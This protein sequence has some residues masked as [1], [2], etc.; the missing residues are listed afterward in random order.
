[1]SLKMLGVG[2][3]GRLAVPQGTGD[4]KSWD[5]YFAPDDDIHGVIVAG[6]TQAAQ[7]GAACHSSQ[8]GFT[9]Q[10]IAGVA[11]GDVDH[12]RIVAFQH[13]LLLSGNRIPYMDGIV[14]IAGGGQKFRARVQY[15][16]QRKDFII[17]LTGET[18][19]RPETT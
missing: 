6:L 11:K 8:Y 3:D 4:V 1:M 16:T 17:G 5:T 12:F 15:G 7:K 18:T 13:D 10:D 19:D 2:A 14:F 9:D